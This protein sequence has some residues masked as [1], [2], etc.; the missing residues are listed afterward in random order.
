MAPNARVAAAVAS[1]DVIGGEVFRGNPELQRSL[2]RNADVRWEWYPN[3]GEVVSV[4][5]FGKQFDD[6]IERVYRATSNTSAP[7]IEF[8]NADE[9]VNWGVEL[10]ARKGLAFLGDRLRALSVFSNVTLM[11]IVSGIVGLK[12]AS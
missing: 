10:E 2:I 11:L 3:P 4:A 12:L 8:V 9:A 6:P 1:R 5:A 7:V